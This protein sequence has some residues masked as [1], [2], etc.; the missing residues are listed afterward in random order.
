M[1][2]ESIPV[3]IRKSPPETCSCERPLPRE[4]AEWKGASR[5][6]CD[7][8]GLPVPLRLSTA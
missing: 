1:H 3:V 7:R 8:C 2:P 6:T 5:T 4:R